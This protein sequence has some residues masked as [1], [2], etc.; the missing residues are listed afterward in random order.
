MSRRK[1]NANFLVSEKGN[2]FSQKTFLSIFL[3]CG[4]YWFSFE[5]ALSVDSGLS[6]RIVFWASVVNV[7]SQGLA[8]LT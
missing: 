1:L 5:T 7:S 4:N 3:S 2:C 6:M 8:D